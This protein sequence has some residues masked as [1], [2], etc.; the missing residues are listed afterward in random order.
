MV[1]PM[2]WSVVFHPEVDK[3]L[4]MLDNDSYQQVIA[5]VRELRD[6]GPALGR[7]LADTVKASRHKNMKELRPGSAGRSEIRVLFA[8]DPERRAILLVAG[9]KAGRWKRW[10]KQAIRLA[11]DRFD[12][13]IDR[14]RKRENDDR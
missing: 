14:M 11:D 3:W 8:F 6:I 1:M 4:Q 12:E 9:D 13:H 10:Y 2:R 7:P 5:A